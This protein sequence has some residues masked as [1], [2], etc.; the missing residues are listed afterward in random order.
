MYAGCAMSRESREYLKIGTEQDK[1]GACACN[2]IGGGGAD[3]VKKAA[4]GAMTDNR[5]VQVD[6]PSVIVHLVSAPMK[7]GSAAGDEPG[8]G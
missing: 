5:R 6:N 4:A 8:C 2:A 3:I 1:T 7:A